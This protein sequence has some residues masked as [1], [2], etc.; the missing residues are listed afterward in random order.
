MKVMLLV[1]LLL[2]LSPPVLEQDLSHSE[3]SVLHPQTLQGNLCLQED[4]KVDRPSLVLEWQRQWKIPEQALRSFWHSRGKNKWWL[5]MTHVTALIL[6][7]GSLAASCG[8]SGC[9]VSFWCFLAGCM[10]L[11]ISTIFESV[12]DFTIVRDSDSQGKCRLDRLTVWFPIAKKYFQAAGLLCALLVASAILG[13]SLGLLWGHSSIFLWSQLAF[14]STLGFP[15]EGPASRAGPYGMGSAHLDDTPVSIRV[16]NTFVEINDGSNPARQLRASTSEPADPCHSLTDIRQ[17]GVTSELGQLSLDE[18]VLPDAM[19]TDQTSQQQ[20]TRRVYCPVPG[21]VCNDPVRAAGWQS[22][23][24]MRS[25]LDEH[26]CGRLAGAIPTT[27]LATHSLGQCVVCSRLL[28]Q[29]YGSCCPRCRPALSSASA[30]SSSSGRPL[31]QGSPDLDEACTKKIPVKRHVP[32]GA[33]KWWSMCL[34]SALANVVQYNDTTAWTDLTSLPK[35]VLAAEVRGGRQHSKRFEA[36]TKMRCQRWL[37]GERGQLWFHASR[38]AST[39]RGRKNVVKVNGDNFKIQRA[40]EF[41]REGLLHHACGSLSRAPPVEITDLVEEQMR[42][43]HPKARQADLS[44][45]L[46]VRGIS[47][48]AALAVD[49]EAVAKAVSSFSRGSGGGMSGLRPIHIKEAMVPFMRDEVV[50]QLTEVVNL[51]AQGCVVPLL[52]HFRK[53][54]VTYAP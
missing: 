21:C 12:M 42:K 52:L 44:R 13:G 23:S 50:K 37:E 32:K 35:M 27:W 9:L 41:L 38:N 48:A 36:G 26:A 43:K 19:E 11:V 33:R 10:H 25:H 28:S 51:M 31:P 30:S 1:C 53:K 22:V 39:G 54:M 49:S 7:S 17:L 47:P 20:N 40:M 14:D 46:E 8:I 18:D 6:G 45:L 4:L 34:L 15:G 5:W 3:L 29:R 2:A 24:N 16:R